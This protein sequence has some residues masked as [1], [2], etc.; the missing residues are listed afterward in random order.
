[1]GIP[2]ACQIEVV[3]KYSERPCIP[4]YTEDVTHYCVLKGWNIQ[5]KYVYYNAN[6][7]NLQQV[8]GLFALKMLHGTLACPQMFAF[9]HFILHT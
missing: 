7:N 5:P 1:M 6:V 8:H 2:Y 9:I 4:K 3:E